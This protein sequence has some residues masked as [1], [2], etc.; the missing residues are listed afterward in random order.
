MH[1]WTSSCFNV[2]NCKCCASNDATKNTTLLCK[3]TNAKHLNLLKYTRILKIKQNKK[4]NK[5]YIKYNKFKWHLKR[6]IERT[7]PN[8]HAAIAVVEIIFHKSLYESSAHTRPQVDV[9][10]GGRFGCEC[11]KKLLNWHRF[12]FLLQ[13]LTNRYAKKMHR[14]TSYME[15]KSK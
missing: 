2:D 5:T 8:I 3:C 4:K 1:I 14:Y 12:P 11:V 9:Q 15:E 13:Q 7:T 10:W 6:S